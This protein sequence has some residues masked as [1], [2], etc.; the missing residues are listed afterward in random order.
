MLSADDIYRY[1]PWWVS[2]GWEADDPHL[3]RLRARATQLPSPQVEEV[4][5]ERPAVHIL[6]GPRQVGKSTDLKLLVRR[7]R[8]AGVA[9]RRIVYLSL[10]L[11]EDRPA[12]ELAATVGRA[13]ELAGGESVPPR[14]ILLDEVTATQG[15]RT[16]VK[17][18][19]DDG[20]IDRDIVVCTGSSA[21]D[22]TQAPE[23]LPGRRGA[24][25]D[26]LV[27]PSGFATFARTVDAR[28]PPGL[29]L[30]VAEIL[31]GD[32]RTAL[33]DAQV[34]LPALRTML[35]RHLLF[36]GLPAAVA[37]A[38]AGLSR[39]S[40][41]VQR[42]LWDS[43]VREVQRRGASISAAQ[44]LLERIV[45]SLGAK[46]SWSRLARELAVPLGA[47]ARRRS[48]DAND[49]RTVQ[50][51]VEM[52]AINYFA[53]VLHFWKADSG[54]GDLA[55]G[56][57]VYFGDPLLQ[58]I[59]A[60]RVG[61]PRNPHADVENALALALYRRYEPA[62]RSA[63]GFRGPERLHVWGTRR[64][65]EIDF[66]CGSRLAVEAVE[67]A[68]WERVSRQKATAPMRALPGRPSLVATRDEL[69]FTPTANLVPAA[70]L[71][72]ALSD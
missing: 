7:A 8:A 35:D 16:A 41:E 40:E 52:L 51:Y 15:W 47:A 60:A 68:D 63:E 42:V 71:L 58:S 37:E 20:R 19:W 54:S 31:T 27:L 62:E 43:L 59:T 70:L 36:G 30:T 4:D 67:V 17:V 14:L 2:D 69:A 25:R 64:G 57:K 18:L 56:K 38:A 1:N 61:L 66:V 65:G 28:I 49:P 26:M 44:A 29:G 39:P 3:R 24:G 23:R 13:L 21:I 11:L 33:R 34:H 53:L 55:K 50:G 45:R 12:A 72:W 32:G 10:D 5:L 46:V 9:S 22:L 48:A 6:R